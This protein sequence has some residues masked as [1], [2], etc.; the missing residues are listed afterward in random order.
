MKYLTQIIFFIACSL[1]VLAEP[2]TFT[3]SQLSVESPSSS[4]ENKSAT[5]AENVPLPDARRSEMVSRMES[6]VQK[7]AGEYG[8]PV[9]AQFFTNDKSKVEEM[10]NRLKTSKTLDELEKSVS[11]LKNQEAALRAELLHLQ[12]ELNS[13]KKEFEVLKNKTERAQSILNEM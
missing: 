12:N 10:R 6:A 13:A 7:V 2:V 5:V 11:D 9:F 4:Q 8:N 1:S 3:S